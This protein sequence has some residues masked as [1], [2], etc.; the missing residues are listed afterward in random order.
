M[1]GHLEYLTE[2]V[3]E[4]CLLD[5]SGWLALTGTPGVT[6]TGYFHAITTGEGMQQWPTHHWTVLD[7]PYIP[8]AAEWLREK[9]EK[10][11]LD[12]TSPS[13]LREWMGQWVLDTES[14]CYP[15]DGQINREFGSFAEGSETDWRYIL[16]VDLGV[17][18]AS[19]FVVIAYRPAMPTIHIIESVAFEGLSPSGA[20][21]K[22]LAYRDRFRGL[23]VVA[24]TGGIGKGFVEE[25]I[26]RFSL[27]VERAMKLDV[28]GQIALVSG[29]MRSGDVKVHTPASS[30]LIA[31][32][33]ALP[34]NEDR[35]GHDEGY[36]D[37][38]SDAARYAIL[39]AQPRYKGEKD[40]PEPGTP[41]HVRMMMDKQREAA[42]KRGAKRKIRNLL[43]E[44]EPWVKIAA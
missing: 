32:W 20:A 18:D 5:Y 11:G 16:G 10:L 34:W 29:L 4:P 23:R 38:Q 8:H 40:L 30:G 6:P 17:N 7:N 15:Y 1:R 43:T 26:Q 2:D 12:P 19:A 24:D 21:A 41:E 25:W 13:Y 35:D 27:P 36:P 39:A 14:L 31:E 42:F 28:R 44:S 3:L 33:Q 22:V 37:H 9:C